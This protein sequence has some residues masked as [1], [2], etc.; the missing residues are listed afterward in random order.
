MALKTFK[1]TWSHGFEATIEAADMRKEHPR[2]RFLD[3]AGREIAS[4]TDPNIINC[5]ET[6]GASHE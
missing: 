3:D 4:Y 2:Y 5:E 1:L 6:E